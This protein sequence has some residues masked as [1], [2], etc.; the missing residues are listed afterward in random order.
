MVN[1]NFALVPFVIQEILNKAFEYKESEPQVIEEE[2]ELTKLFPFK[3]SVQ[4]GRNTL[5]VY[6]EAEAEEGRN[7]RLGFHINP[8]AFDSG[9]E[10]DLFRY[11]RDV[12]DEDET[13]KDVYFTGARV[14]ADP[15]RT[16]FYFEYWS[17]EQK[18][19]ARYFPDFLIETTKRFIVVEAKGSDEKTDYETNKKS[20]KGKIEHLTNE[21]L[22][23]EIGFNEFQSVN[24]NFEYHIIFD[25][26]LQREQLRL[27]EEIRNQ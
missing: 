25:A 27:L 10:K 2:I 18:R 9:D 15:S 16:D 23:K 11:L 7:G 24:K 19:V 4:Q 5:V 8:Y 26:S 20:Y 12:L 13:I 21:I 17:P 22:A 6:K 1:E 14:C 3:I